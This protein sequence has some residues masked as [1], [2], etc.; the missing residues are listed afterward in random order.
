MIPIAR[1]EIILKVL[2]ESPYVSIAELTR[3]LKVSH[4]TVRRDLQKLEEDGL[5]IQ[6]TGGVKAARRLH[7]E[8][9]HSEKETLAGDEKRRIG[10]AAAKMIPQR[11]CIYLDAGTTSLAL[12]RNLKDRDDLTIISNDLVVMH[13]L[14]TNS[15]NTLIMTGG[16]VR[17]ENLSTVGHLAA[18]TLKELSC[19]IAF[20][21]ASS[22]DLRGI[23]TPDPDKVPVKQTAAASAGRRVLISDSSKYGQFA[24]YIAVPLK[25][26][27]TIISDS[28][29]SENG[30][31]GLQKSGVELILV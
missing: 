2:D 3:L 6:V 26:I 24:T 27:N 17:S 7:I 25:E 22:F 8:P 16:L 12:C 31:K 19:D 11:A 28:S 14:A 20:L 5:V 30:Q 4:M 23:T 29:L 10:E 15:K 9:S 13:F 21:S 1:H 18:E